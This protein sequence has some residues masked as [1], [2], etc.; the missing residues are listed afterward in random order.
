MRQP[1]AD[2]TLQLVTFS[3]AE[4]AA[5]FLARQRDPSMFA[6]FRQQRDGRILHVVVYG[7]FRTRQ[8]AAEAAAHLPEGV[9]RL[10]PWIRP[11]RDVQTA[12]RTALQ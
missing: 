9:G 6:R 12:V 2:Y 10:K 8:A 7:S 5:S 4:R 11:F 3:T 1:P